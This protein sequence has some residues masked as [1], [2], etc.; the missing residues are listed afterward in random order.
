MVTLVGGQ[1]VYGTANGATPHDTVRV[2][3][4][5]RPTVKLRTHALV[6]GVFLGLVALYTPS[7]TTLQ[8]LEI[9]ESYRPVVMLTIFRNLLTQPRFLL[10]G[11]GFYPFG[12]SLTLMEPYLTPALIMG[13]LSALL[14]DPVAAYKVTIAVFWAASGWAMYA[15]TFWLTQCHPAAVVAALVFTVCPARLQYYQS[16]QVQLLFGIPLAVYGLVRFL[17][18][19][20]ARHLALVLGV[21]W[22]QA[23]AVVYW[24]VMLS[25]GLA[26]VA[27][28]Y[29]A[30]R[31]RGW[32]LATVFMATAGGGLLTLALVPVAWPYFVT[33]QELG[34]E[35]TL[36]DA[37]T[38]NY[39]ADLLAYV[40]TGGTWLARWLPIEGDAEAPLFVGLGALS[41]AALSFWGVRRGTALPSSRIASWLRGG[42]WISVGLALMAV[43]VGRPV[44]VGPVRSLFSVAGVGLLLCLVAR[45]ATEGWVRWRDGL[46]ERRLTANEWIRLL[47][48]LVV[49]A[50][51][52]SLG[53][54]P[55]VGG[56]ALG[57]GLHA[58][59]YPYVFP[60][61]AIRLVTRFGMVAMFG[62]ALLAGFGMQALSERL[63]PWARRVTA[64]VIPLLLLLEGAGVS[65][66]YA[67]V[68]LP[69]RAVDAV[70]R[71]DPRDAVVLE[72]PLNVPDSDA[73]ATFRSLAHGKRVVNGSGG[74]ALELQRELS[75]LLSTPSAPFPSRE[76]QAALQR[77][78]SLRY[79]VVRLEDPEVRP[80][81]P[82]WEVLRHAPPPL[83]QFRG[84]FGT[85]DLYEIVSLPDRAMTVE[86]L[87]SYDVIRRNPVAHFTL[88][89]VAS[90]P[91]REQWV[92]ASLNGRLLTRV[93]LDG[94]QPVTSTVTLTPPYRHTAPN[95]LTLRAR[96]APR[97]TQ[98]AS[99]QI[100][101]TGAVSP[102]DLR[103]L[104]VGKPEGSASSIQL[105]GVEFTPDQRGYNVVA[106]A[107]GGLLL[108]ADAFDT[109]LSEQANHRLTVWVAALPP[110]TIVAGAV[111]DEASRA[112]T[113]EAV[114]ALRTLGVAGD[115][116]GHSREAH[117]FIG[118][119]G[120]PPGSALEA[121]GPR[122]IQLTVGYFPVH[123]GFELADLSLRAQ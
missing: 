27:I 22:L 38:S 4:R 113:M 99:Y 48:S 40:T 100:G 108:A 8:G 34:F 103:V 111:R 87:V 89:P 35:R 94:S 86:R 123:Q 82:L 117:A 69:P 64:A 20:R 120:A 122:M 53:P 39:S 62:V 32:R 13:P 81:R 77:L 63:P 85:E 66:G 30:L 5:I 92:D 104:S 3:D 116:R 65:S 23:V 47:W 98:D 67:A 68:R 96:Y 17:E 12:T 102:G 109:Y 50:V 44:G 105:N 24:A 91:R 36:E 37:L 56:K 26:L 119:K 97:A 73:E 42:A 31:W 78:Y 43:A 10:E 1:P 15:V 79:L 115:L 33:R 95:V 84:T 28:N 7:L 107:P 71:A 80:Q 19:Q 114:W 52:L 54:L 106:F 14:S 55:H 21:F 57:T 45:Q 83:L 49:V 72:W 121:L 74:F 70:I 46:R 29:L 59:L 60:F 75:T 88:R 112:L 58:W 18:E 25:V 90:D 101:R 11:P 16:L 76:A 93:P 41:L 61:R 118:V 110:G 2:N 6:F 9:S 51:L